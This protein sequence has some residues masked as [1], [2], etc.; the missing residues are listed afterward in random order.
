MRLSVG[1]GSVCLL[2]LAVGGHSAPP[3]VRADGPRVA[4]E[5]EALRSS[6]GVVR[7]ALFRS[8]HGWA[9]HGREIATCR[10]PI[11]RGRATCSL[12]VAPGEY[13]FAFMHDEDDDGQLDR[14]WIGIPQ[15]GFGFSNDAAPALGPPSFDS[16]RFAH[17]ASDT[18]IVVRARYGL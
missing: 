5:I 2:L 4:V 12:D 17:A 1:S 7:G 8:R 13:A 15:E 18:T 10:A 6:R 9:E 14:D 3:P 11:D 16:A